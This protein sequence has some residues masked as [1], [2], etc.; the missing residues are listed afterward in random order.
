MSAKKLN[1]NTNNNNNRKRSN[2]DEESEPQHEIDEFQMDNI[3]LDAAESS[4]EEGQENEDENGEILDNTEEDFQDAR[5]EQERSFNEEEK[6]DSDSDSDAEFN[7][8]LAKENES[9]FNENYSDDSTSS[10]TN[11]EKSI[12]DKLTN[13]KLN[14]IHEPASI[15]TEYSDGTPRLLKPEIDPIYDSDDTDYEQKTN[16]IGNIP[17]SAYDEMPHIG[18]DI[19]GKRIMRPAKGSALDQLLENIELPEGWTGLLDKNTGASLN[20]SEEELELIKKIERNENTTDEVDPYPKY[21]DWFTRDEQLTPVT[22]IPEPK[23]RFIPS[24]IEAKRVMKIVKAIREGRIIPPNKLKELREE[25]NKN[26][27]LWEG[28]SDDA[29]DDHIMNLRAPKL[30]PPTNEESYNPPEEYLMTKE[31]IE[32]WEKLEPSEREKNFVPQKYGSLRKVPGY[33]ESV[34]ERFERSLDLY[35]APRVR[36][37]KLNIDPES[38]I[39]D[40]PSPKDLKPFPIRCSTIYKGHTG[41]IRTVSIDPSGLWLATGSDDGTVRIWEILTGR[42]VYKVSIIDGDEEETE[43]HIDVVAWNPDKSTGI[44]AIAC[45]EQITLIVPPIFG[46]EIE[47][48][49][50][51]KIENGFGFDTFGNVKKDGKLNVNEDEDLDD[52]NERTNGKKKAPVA[53]WN[54]PT[55]KQQAKDIS[56]TI[57]CNK[58]VKKLSWH[59]KGDYFVTVQPESGNTSVLIHQL[60][61]HMSQ[62]PFKKSKGII[63]DAKFHPFRPQLFVCS[64]RYIR[65]YDLSQQ[66]LVKKL[67]PGARWLSKIDIHPRGDNL[68]ASSFDKRV[69]WHD[70]DLSNIPYKTLRYHDKAVRDVEFHKKL[71]LFCSAADDGTI[72]IFHDTVYDDMMKNPLIVPLKKLTGHKVINSLGV[73]NTAWHP[74]EAWLFS[75]GADHTAR[76]WTN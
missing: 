25:E 47:N 4:D 44:L 71:P 67:L 23:R 64:Q 30:P 35:L 36:K 51:L 58:T 60:S 21:I 11:D 45:G 12:T 20:L 57:T 38:L 29:I 56:I 26:Y 37:N 50:K 76:L 3:Q 31:E 14:I 72:H 32:N 55:I 24:K 27:D 7:K 69:L 68:I 63:M 62:S 66:I 46:F 42:E 33:T 34:R 49:G 52:N 65:I 39:P 8:I 54:K 10:S 48:N 6:E 41:R 74:R 70:L 61:K 40:L 13:T 75:A 59:R 18:Y 73:L 1:Q 17:L 22:A 53:K 16:T 43:D 15:K 9:S 19:N 5:E 2:N 28:T